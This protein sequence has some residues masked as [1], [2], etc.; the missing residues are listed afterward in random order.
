MIWPSLWDSETLETLGWVHSQFSPLTP[1]FSA[2]WKRASTCGMTSA[3]LGSLAWWNGRFTWNLKHDNKLWSNKGA[4]TGGCSRTAQPH[5][6]AA[7]HSQYRWERISDHLRRC[8]V[9]HCSEVAPIY[10]YT[11]QRDI[12]MLY[13]TSS[14]KRNRCHELCGIPKSTNACSTMRLYLRHKHRVT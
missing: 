9:N 10:T 6:I 14:K 11:D 2:K 7:D 4:A 12:P 1:Q 13:L 8:K 3:R 5:C